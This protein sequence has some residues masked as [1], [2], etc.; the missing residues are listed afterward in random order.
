MN[1]PFRYFTGRRKADVFAS[2]NTP[3]LWHGRP[4]STAHRWPLGEGGKAV[5]GE[6]IELPTNGLQIGCRTLTTC[7][8]ALT[9]ITD[10]TTYRAE[11]P[12]DTDLVHLRRADGVTRHTAAACVP[13]V[14][15]KERPSDSQ[16]PDGR[17]CGSV[18]VRSQRRRIRDG[19]ARSLFLIIEPSGHKSWQMRFRTPLGRIG[20]LTLG[21]P[22][23]RDRAGQRAT[24]HG[25]AAP[26]LLRARHSLHGSAPRAGARARGYRRP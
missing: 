25:H 14:H 12:M 21:P 5:P 19:G 26:L 24:D 11:I 4:S 15:P 9:L 8:Q 23:H 20:R 6:R 13:R 3:W 1:S 7:Y 10:F 18:S 2:S 22:T 16:A 17:G